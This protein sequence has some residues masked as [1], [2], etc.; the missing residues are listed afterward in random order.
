MQSN[1]VVEES[2][3]EEMYRL[4]RPEGDEGDESNVCNVDEMKQDVVNNPT[5]CMKKTHQK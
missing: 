3:Q 1:T 2:K 5:N 4:G